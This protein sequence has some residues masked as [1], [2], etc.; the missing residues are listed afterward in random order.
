MKTLRFTCTL[1]TGL[2]LVLLLFPPWSEYDRFN[3]A[4]LDPA[5]SSLG[6]NWRFRP[7]SHWGYVQ[8]YHCTDS[9]GRDAVCGGESVWE[10][11][12][13]AV[14]DYPMLKYEAVLGLV[15][16]TFF[17]LIANWIGKCLPNSFLFFKDSV[18]RMGR[19]VLKNKD[20]M[21]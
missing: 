21:A 15:A 10:P 2:M 4:W 16:S 12:E 19:R 9:A 3:P 5:F 13:D 6:H 20:P 17:A 1:Y 8:P 7:P 18:F 11:N 14:I